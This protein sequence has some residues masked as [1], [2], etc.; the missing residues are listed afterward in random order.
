MLFFSLIKHPTKCYLSK[1]LYIKIGYSP[2]CSMLTNSLNNTV[3]KAQDIPVLG[4]LRD[5]SYPS[6]WQ[7]SWESARGILFLK[8]IVLAT[9]LRKLVKLN[10]EHL[11]NITKVALKISEF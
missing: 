4:I 8:P 10:G 1:I 9:W 11:N 3:E 7:Q 2:P 6:L 5:A